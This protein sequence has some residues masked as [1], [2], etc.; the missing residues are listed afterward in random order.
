MCA[1]SHFTSQCHHHRLSQKL[2]DSNWNCCLN[3]V[4]ILFRL[5]NTTSYAS[6]H[7]NGAIYFNLSF[8]QL[9]NSQITKTLMTAIPP[10]NRP[11]K[12]CKR[13]EFGG[14]FIINVS[15]SSTKRNYEN[16]DCI[17]KNPSN[18][19]WQ[20]CK[21]QDKKCQGNEKHDK[22]TGKSGR[23]D[24]R[25]EYSNKMSKTEILHKHT[26]SHTERAKIILIHMVALFIKTFTHSLT[27]TAQKLTN[28]SD[29]LQLKQ[30][31]CEMRWIYFT[32]VA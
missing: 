12:T 8:I 20:C 13:F 6:K 28:Q 18:V 29:Q 27:H 21:W 2:N 25:T 24:G 19:V 7:S 3:S 26:H 11:T 15:F 31:M 17:W 32:I 22:E 4:E 23:A 10:L 5:K 30:I 1:I 14:K 16:N 9:K